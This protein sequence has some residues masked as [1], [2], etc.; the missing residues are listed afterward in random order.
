MYKKKK[1]QKMVIKHKEKNCLEIK[2]TYLEEI[3]V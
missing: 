2:R 1:K 3:Y